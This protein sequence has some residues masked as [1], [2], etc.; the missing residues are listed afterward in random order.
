MQ[1]YKKGTAPKKYPTKAEKGQGSA[2]ASP[3]I[4]HKTAQSPAKQPRGPNELML[5]TIAALGAPVKPEWLEE[6][7]QL[8]RDMALA[9]SGNQKDLYEFNVKRPS[10]G[11]K[12]AKCP[13]GGS[14]SSIPNVGRF[15]FRHAAF[16]FHDTTLKSLYRSQLRMRLSAASSPDRLQHRKRPLAPPRTRR[17]RRRALHKHP[18]RSLRWS[19]PPTR[20]PQQNPFR[21]QTSPASTHASVCPTG[22]E[23]PH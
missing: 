5:Q 1:R 3:S 16:R 4:Q 17:K 8:D 2:N 20:N 22:C 9:S 6:V 12:T 7:R 21:L 14:P 11:V 18:P 23:R 19:D 15:P 10:D 13:N